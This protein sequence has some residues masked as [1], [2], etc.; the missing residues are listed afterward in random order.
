M[1]FLFHHSLLS[2]LHQPTV[3]QFPA[4]PPVCPVFCSVSP[5]PIE[6]IGGS[7]LLFTSGD[8]DEL[9]SSLGYIIGTLDDLLCEKLVI[10]SAGCRVRG[11]SFATLHL[12]T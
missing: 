11:R 3:L 5:A 12:Q 1:S 9:L 6:P 2:H 8:G 10:N 7:L 4:L